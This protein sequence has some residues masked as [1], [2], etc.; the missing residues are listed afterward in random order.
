MTTTTEKTVQG[1]T[2][3]TNINVN[4]VMESIQ[5][6]LTMTGMLGMPNR[7]LALMHCQQTTI[8]HHLLQT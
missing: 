3:H 8:T 2:V 1:R 6:H 5:R 4:C 7:I